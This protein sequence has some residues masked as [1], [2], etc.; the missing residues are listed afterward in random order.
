MSKGV[1][2]EQSVLTMC[3]ECVF[4]SVCVY[5]LVVDMLR[6]QATV[7]VVCVGCRERSISCGLCVAGVFV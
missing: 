3:G 2:N 4:I 1:A 6:M 7:E 5:L